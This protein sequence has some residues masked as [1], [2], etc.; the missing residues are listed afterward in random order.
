MNDQWG[1]DRVALERRMGSGAKVSLEELDGGGVADVKEL[2][3]LYAEEL[4]RSQQ[5]EEAKRIGAIAA[6]PAQHF[7]VSV[8]QREQTDPSV[9]TE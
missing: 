6:R 7:L 3:G 9:S 4:E 2:L 8:P 5:P 1:L